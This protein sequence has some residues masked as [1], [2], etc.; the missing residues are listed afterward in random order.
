MIFGEKFISAKIA[1]GEIHFRRKSSSAKMEVTSET[2]DREVQSRYM[3]NHYYEFLSQ[4]HAFVE[5]Q[6]NEGVYERNWRILSVN[7]YFS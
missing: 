3:P 6:H 7:R 5:Q 2:R 4:A 1:F